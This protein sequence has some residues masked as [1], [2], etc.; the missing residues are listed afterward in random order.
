MD[1]FIW[2]IPEVIVWADIRGSEG[3]EES[4][5]LEA[6][7]QHWDGGRACHCVIKEA[8]SKI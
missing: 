6:Q 4:L 7:G 2:M 1:I 3:A 8:I 5:Q